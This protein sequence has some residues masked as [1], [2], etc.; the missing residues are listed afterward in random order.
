MTQLKLI[1]QFL[2]LVELRSDEV[3]GRIV[4]ILAEHFSLPVCA[5][6][7][8]DKRSPDELIL[9]GQC[10][11]AKQLCE[12]IRLSSTDSFAGD[13][14]HRQAPQFTT[15]AGFKSEPLLKNAVTLHKN[16]NSLVAFPLSGKGI[17]TGLKLKDFPYAVLYLYLQ[18]STSI[19][20]KEI[21]NDLEQ[22]AFFISDVY[23]RSVVHDK[24][25]LR[26][27]VVNQAFNTKDLN[28]CLF[29]ILAILQ[30]NWGIEAA[31]VYMLDERA[32]KLRLNQTTG[33][34]SKAKKENVV[35]SLNRKDINNG[36][37]R[38]FQSGKVLR[39]S[40]M[41]GEQ[42]TTYWFF[43]LSQTRTSKLNR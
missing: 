6:Y 16:I 24:I 30:R 8:F 27:E 42:E 15:D 5:F 2:T 17:N 35:I 38:C 32:Q 23:L 3:P 39:E 12:D 37:L 25:L 40:V 11:I 20:G 28:S 36:V 14:L 4:K 9:L 19:K 29:K 26:R 18:E 33:L 21:I 31:S 43:W 1:K 34:M 22:L 41:T 10:G 7:L 13:C